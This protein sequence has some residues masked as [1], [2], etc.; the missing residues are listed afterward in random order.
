MA[1]PDR[2]SGRDD[3]QHRVSWLR[4]NCR[5]VNQVLK[6]IKQAYLWAKERRQQS[7]AA[8]RA[9][10]HGLTDRPLGPA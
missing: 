2:V 10:L 9:V 5:Q 1:L 7:Y 6:A 4:G 8:P 3:E